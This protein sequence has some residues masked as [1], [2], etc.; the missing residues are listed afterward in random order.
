MLLNKTLKQ[1]IALA[2]TLKIFVLK[3]LDL[4]DTAYYASVHM[5]RRHTVVGLCMYLC[6]CLSVTRNS[7][8]VAK[9]QALANAVQA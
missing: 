6:I 5:H 9:N 4:I 8:K 2:I 3:L 7:S 1:I